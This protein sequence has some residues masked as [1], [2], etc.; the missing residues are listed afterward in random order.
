MTLAEIKSN[1]QLRYC[2]IL[3][4]TSKTSVPPVSGHRNPMVIH[5]ESYQPTQLIEN[6]V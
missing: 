4:L 3:A 2:W 6:N 1:G 5:L